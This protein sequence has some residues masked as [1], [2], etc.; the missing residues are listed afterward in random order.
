MKTE[1]PESNFLTA[2]LTGIAITIA[3]GAIL[4]PLVYLAFSAYF[5]LY[6]FTDPPPDAWI[7]DMLLVVVFCV[8]ILLATAAGGWACAG[9]S[10][11]NE[12]SHALF[13]A[14]LWT[15]IAFLFQLYFA[16]EEFY[17]TLSGIALGITGYF[18][19]TGLRIRKKRKAR[20]TAK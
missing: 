9:V 16:K 17:I 8:W 11:R 13:L 12:Y 3:A 18:A 6:I 15:V 1:I 2:V 10:E 14:I 4:F 5:E 7:K 19:G 20:Q